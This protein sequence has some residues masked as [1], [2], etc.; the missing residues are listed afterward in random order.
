MRRAISLFTVLILLVIGGVMTQR[1]LTGDFGF[2]LFGF[3]DY[4]MPELGSLNLGPFFVAIS[5]LPGLGWVGSALPD[6]IPAAPL[7]IG[8]VLILLGGTIATGIALAV[9][10]SRTTFEMVK[11]RKLPPPSGPTYKQEKVPPYRPISDRL[12]LTLLVIALILGGLWAAQKAVSPLPSLGTVTVPI[13]QLSGGTLEL[14]PT[15][16]RADVLF[17][18][19]AAVLV[20]GTLAVGFG[21]AFWFRRTTEEMEKEKA[22]NPKAQPPKAKAQVEVAE[23]A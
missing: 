1:A 21:L 7:L 3:R 4:P 12:A 22:K 8:L 10:T 19:L 5:S 11:E 23:E 17:G 16:F 13:P 2:R 14:A 15:E 9:W 20:L 18:G 6:S